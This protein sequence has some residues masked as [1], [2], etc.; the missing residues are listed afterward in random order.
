MQ[1]QQVISELK[2][3]LKPLVS[4]RATM[5]PEPVNNSSQL[6]EMSKKEQ[7]NW[8]WEAICDR[9]NLVCPDWQVSYA[10]PVL[11]SD[12]ITVRCRLTIAG[13]TREA[14]GSSKGYLRLRNIN[15]QRG[16]THQLNSLNTPEQAMINAFVNAAAQFGI[17]A[18]SSTLG[19]QRGQANRQNELLTATHKE[20]AATVRE[21]G[22]DRP[23]VS[24]LVELPMGSP[25][26]QMISPKQ[27][28]PRSSNKKLANQSSRKS[29]RQIR[30]LSL[31]KRQEMLEISQML[32]ELRQKSG[33]PAKSTIQRSALGRLKV[34]TQRLLRKVLF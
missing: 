1:F 16:I 18:T 21:Y 5:S 7:S 12:Y 29:T 4:D 33:Q 23:H 13:V 24:K 9:L 3:P 14:T 34:S 19:Q 8:Q 31:A 22:R 17:T 20:V 27:Q 25:R 10:D 30:N 28:R 11:V 2:K 15:E 6:A 26:Q 32:R